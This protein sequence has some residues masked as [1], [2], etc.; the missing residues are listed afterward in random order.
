VVY[1]PAALVSA[2]PAYP[3][4]PTGS[5]L[6]LQYRRIAEPE[7]PGQRT[8]SNLH[9]DLEQLLA[10]GYYPVN[11]R[12]LV[13]NR[14]SSVPAGKRP[15]VL[16]FDGSSEDQFRLLHDG[17]VDPNTAVGILKAFH[18][19]HL[20]DWPLRATFCVSPFSEEPGQGPFGRRELSAQKLALL[21]HGGW[22]SA[23]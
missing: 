20:A 9:A 21:A 14:L 8:P 15:I 1:T 11:L 2:K 18:D 12:D 13:E 3:P 7:G 5:V 17:T 23:D 10:V 4:N 19:A 16:T 6:V 22:R